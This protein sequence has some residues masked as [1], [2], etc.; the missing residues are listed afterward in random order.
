MTKKSF[1]EILSEQ[2]RLVY[3]NVGDSMYPLIQPRDLLVIEKPHFP[4]KKYDVPLYR[5]DSGGKY[6]LHRIVKVKNGRYYIC[7]DNRFYLEKGI[8]DRNIIGV[9]TALIRNG[10][11]IRLNTGKYR[12]YCAPLCFRRLFLHIRSK[13]S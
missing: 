2:G 3:T 9:L 11:T 8:E 10:E 13:L 1:E 12:F 6:V 5:R 4:M 7:G